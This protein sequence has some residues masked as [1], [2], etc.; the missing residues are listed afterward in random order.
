MP[1]ISSLIVKLL[2]GSALMIL[3]QVLLLQDILMA[4]IEGSGPI[5]LG[6]NSAQI[7]VLL[8]KTKP[9]AFERPQQEAAKNLAPSSAAPA[10]Q[11]TATP[12]STAAP[13]NLQLQVSLSSSADFQP[14]LLEW[15]SY[16]A[17]LLGPL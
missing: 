5:R 6:S 14:H 10:A 2:M 4:G 8:A 17:P 9:Q 3:T 11:S 13:H 12:T 7:P 16:S 15:L 1:C